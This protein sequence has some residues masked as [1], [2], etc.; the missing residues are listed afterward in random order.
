MQQP[1]LGTNCLNTGLLLLALVVDS[2]VVRKLH[3]AV[4][5]RDEMLFEDGEHA[6]TQEGLIEFRIFIFSF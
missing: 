5:G 1:N 4:A 6:G 2:H 3:A